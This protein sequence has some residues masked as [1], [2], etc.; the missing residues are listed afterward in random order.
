M[1]GTV[2]GG[3][4]LLDIPGH[5]DTWTTPV[6]G[7]VGVGDGNVNWGHHAR[8]KGVTATLCGFQTNIPELVN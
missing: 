8:Y 4:V 3:G 7:V 2:T 5:G 1:T 6:H